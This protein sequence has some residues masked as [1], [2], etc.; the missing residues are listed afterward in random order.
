MLMTIK[1]HLTFPIYLQT[2]SLF[3]SPIFELQTLYSGLSF[4]LNPTN[5]GNMSASQGDPPRRGPW[6]SKIAKSVGFSP[7]VE[8]LVK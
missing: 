2:W 5:S 7:P 4:F 3:R 8:M 6:A 1:F